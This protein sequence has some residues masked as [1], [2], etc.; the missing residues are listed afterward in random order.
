M[1]LNRRGKSLTYPTWQVAHL[2]E[3][4]IP[5][6][7]NPA[8]GAL[9]AAFDEVSTAELLPMRQAEECPVRNTIDKVAAMALGIS[10]EIVAEWR[11]KLSREP[12]V[13]NQ[14]AE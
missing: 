6:A 14:R 9:R 12:T 3:I 1:L 8:L 2:R 4:R 10:A 5:K 13:T 11:T 7:D